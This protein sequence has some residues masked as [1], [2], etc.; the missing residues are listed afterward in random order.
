MTDTNS[1]K[2]ENLMRLSRER[3]IIS[4]LVELDLWSQEMDDFVQR[5]QLTF[6]Q[7]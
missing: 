3:L 4:N 1:K 7:C 6:G 5:E 2:D